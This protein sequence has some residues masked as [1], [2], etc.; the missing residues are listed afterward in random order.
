MFVACVPLGRPADDANVVVLEGNMDV[1]IDYWY[2][3]V[4][5]AL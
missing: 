2:E 1:G 5:L 4:P 3:G